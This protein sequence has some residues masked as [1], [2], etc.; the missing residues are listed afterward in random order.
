MVVL[1]EEDEVDQA[2][3]EVG[4]LGEVIGFAD[5]V[6]E[7]IYGL[8]GRYIYHWQEKGLFH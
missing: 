8:G 3:D 2:E 4:A 7:G 5:G 1:E 6:R